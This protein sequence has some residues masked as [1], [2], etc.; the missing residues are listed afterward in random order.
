MTVSTIA[1][2]ERV[3]FQQ[4]LQFGH[5]RRRV[6]RYR[7]PYLIEVDSLRVCSEAD[8]IASLAASSM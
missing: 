3:F 1:S 7:V 6:F 2:G 8:L 4:F 5:Q